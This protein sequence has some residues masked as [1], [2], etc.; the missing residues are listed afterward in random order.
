[1]KFWSKPTKENKKPPK[2]ITKISRW[3]GILMKKCIKIM[4]KVIK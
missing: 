3:K 2:I 1:M 4:F